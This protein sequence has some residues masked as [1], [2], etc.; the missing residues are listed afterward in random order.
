M[1]L[2]MVSKYV[3]SIHLTSLTAVDLTRTKKEIKG[4]LTTK[5]TNKK[6]ESESLQASPVISDEEPEERIEQYIND[7]ETES[8]KENEEEAS[9]ASVDLK[10]FEV[11]DFVIFVYEG[12]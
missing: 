5:I 11:G 2:R 12:Y 3:G 4:E 10:S 8:E 6:K 7:D 9:C 1:S